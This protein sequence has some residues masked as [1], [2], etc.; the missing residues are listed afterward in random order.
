MKLI[1]DMQVSGAW[2][3]LKPQVKAL[4]RSPGVLSGCLTAPTT[5]FSCSRSWGGGS[6][7]EKYGSPGIHRWVGQIMRN[8]VRPGLV[9]LDTVSHGAD[10]SQ[11]RV[12][13]KLDESVTK[14]L[15]QQVFCFLGGLNTILFTCDR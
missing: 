13:P 8:P 6:T 5:L 11:G 12:V 2:R 7:R 3:S 10:A 4:L 1:F 15:F 14:Y 9:P